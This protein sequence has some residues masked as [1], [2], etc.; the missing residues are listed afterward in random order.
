V[1]A[2]GDRTLAEQEWNERVLRSG[3][4]KMRYSATFISQP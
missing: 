2:R 4:V 1:S 3:P